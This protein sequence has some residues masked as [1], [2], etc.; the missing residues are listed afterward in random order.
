MEETKALKQEST[1]QR[2]TSQFLGPPFY[3][4]YD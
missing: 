1:N 4:V 2:V 3:T